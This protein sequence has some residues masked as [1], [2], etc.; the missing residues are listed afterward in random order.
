LLV[1]D[2]DGIAEK[3]SQAL[4]AD[5]RKVVRIQHS[6]GKAGQSEF[7]ADLTDQAQADAL[8]KKVKAKH[9]AIAA[10]VHL[11]ALSESDS[12][13]L[14]PLYSLFNLSK[15]LESDLNRKAEPTLVVSAHK[16]GGL[17]G[18]AQAP[19]NVAQAGLPGVIKSVAREWPQSQGKS[20][21]FDLD[22]TPVQIVD[23]LTAELCNADERVEVA[24]SNAQRFGLEIA[25]TP[26]DTSSPVVNNLALDANSV[27]LVTGGARGITAEIAKQIATN[28][29]SQLVIVGR[30]PRPTA[31]ESAST[32]SLTSQRELKA[33][34]IE[35][36]KKEKKQVS[37][38]EIES[39][40]QKTMRDREIAANLDEL[41]HLGAKVEYQA[42]DVRDDKAFGAL[43]DSIY[44]KHGKID[45]VIHGAG[46]IE[47]AYIKDKAPESFRR[48]VETKALSAFTLRKKLR[49]ELLQFMFLFSSVVG[50]FGNAGQ[51]DY[52]AT[53]EI[54]N[55]LALAMNEQTTGRVAS[56]MWGPW[57]GGMAQPELEAIFAKY[58]WAMIDPVAGPEQFV[59][60]LLRGDK[61]AV[62]VLLVAEVPTVPEVKGARLASAVGYSPA[63]G[64]VQFSLELN[65]A[66]DLYLNDH[67]FDGVPVMPMAMAVELLMEAAQSAYPGYSAE[68]VYDL[69][70]PSGIV[71][72]G[73]S[74]MITVSTELKTR[75]ESGMTVAAVLGIGA[76]MKRSNFKAT[77]KL[78]QDNCSLSPLSE[79]PQWISAKIDPSKEHLKVEAPLVTPPPSVEKIYAEWFFHGPMF[80]GITE[81]T[82]LGKSGV[83]GTVASSQ[84]ARCLAETSGESWTIDPLLLDSSMQLAGTWA[85]HHLEITV[86]PTGFKA[87]HKFARAYTDKLYVRVFVS[88][89][90][91]AIELTCDL[92]VYNEDGTLAFVIEGLG[93]IGSKS[94]N[95]LANQT[96][97]TA[98]R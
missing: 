90:A 15:A 77:V 6:A 70:I 41:E 71:F 93:G 21:D 34:I 49:L 58:G 96:A 32:A 97:G 18:R 16:I 26:I 73:S 64:R 52:V 48:V 78:V 27:I 56:L 54:V 51:A 7:S 82:T 3:L 74:K 31:P 37:V 69:D 89:N 75:S 81:I 65:T 92:A 9:G 84:P 33:A 66:N 29:K 62:E 30:A 87:L 95:R 23:A 14:K 1:D 19:T 2:A 22:T 38:A 61:E 24:Y 94:L 86:L 60:E 53:N 91:S 25:M 12:E 57:R 43:I 17:F 11:P 8:V 45:G 67:T 5:N 4:V 13:S 50:R 40:Y 10:L 35:N 72:E 36:F 68:T 80:Q 59:Q 55:K 47:D 20:I 28:Y 63:P 79:I 42:V 39:I 76:P 83:Y 85:R 88:Q 98:H 46:I 44:K